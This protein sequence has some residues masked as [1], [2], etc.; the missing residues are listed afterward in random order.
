MHLGEQIGAG[1]YRECYAI[2][3]T[4]LCAKKL[5]PLQARIWS[6]LSH[7]LRDINQAE[8]DRWRNI[9]EELKL[10]F[11]NI[12]KKSGK[13]LISERPKDYNGSYS[14]TLLE[15]KSIQNNNFWVLVDFLADTMV[16]HKLWLFDIF[17]F[18]DNILVQKKS[19]NEYVPIIIDC[20][21]F[22]W[23]SYP[24][25]LNLLFYS[26]KKKKFYR[27]LERFKEKFKMEK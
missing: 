22:G 1:K 14:K 20:K 26:E 24:L 10:F 16:K 19:E 15:Y 7:T 12:Y 25:Q 3:D 6:I 9:P 21:R 5:K 11:P 8:L 2:P 23:K 4:N 13:L 18:G 27:K 17:D